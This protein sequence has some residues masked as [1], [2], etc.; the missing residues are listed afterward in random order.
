MGQLPPRGQLSELPLKLAVT[1]WFYINLYSPHKN[2]FFQFSAIFKGLSSSYQVSLLFVQIQKS[3]QQAV[4]DS[5]KEASWSTNCNAKTPSSLQHIV[6]KKSRN[7][8]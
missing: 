1:S 2:I 3:G 7:A 6:F 4:F 5:S 8:L